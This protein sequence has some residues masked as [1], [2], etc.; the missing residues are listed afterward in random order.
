MVGIQGISGIDFRSIME[1]S[2]SQMRYSRLEP[3]ES[4]NSRL[5]AVNSSLGE[6]KTRLNDIRSKGDKFRALY[7]GGISKNAAS[8]DESVF[9]AIA[10]NGANAGNINISVSSVAKNGTL[11]F[12]KRFSG[13]EDTVAAV[14]DNLP[15][16]DRTVSLTIGDADGEQIDI[17]ITSSTTL[18]EF[19][20]SFNEQSENA[21]A[22]LVNVGSAGNPSYAMMITT[23]NSG[24][25]KG[26]ISLNLGSALGDLN[27]FNL[28]QAEDTEL[29][30]DGI[31]GTISRSSSSINDIL[32][33]VTFEIQGTGTSKLSITNDVA[34][35]K[36]DIKELIKSYN[37]LVDYVKGE[38]SVTTD[39]NEV[40]FGSLKD[41]RID[42]GILTNLRS[43]L[44]S[45]RGSA[46]TR[47]FA[48]IGIKTNREGGLDIDE[49]AL[50]EA[51]QNDP[52]GVSKLMESFTEALNNPS[53]GYIPLATRYSG[54]LDVA[55]RGNQTEI[56]RNNSRIAEVEK[57]ILRREE[58]LIAQ[59]GR[60]EG[61]LGSLQAQQSNIASL[62]SSF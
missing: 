42:D 31:T 7:G 47:I 11:S 32:V 10:S 27:T 49:D 51:I 2:L 52:E 28:S 46:T 59:Y 21:E 60:L 13:F 25:D 16:A 37:D 35:T 36:K 44:S 45:A 23:K 41:T 3:L 61:I 43:A 33:G 62:L 8:S 26:S 30:I 1:A 15:A 18:A 34:D 53:T 38:D 24:K 19:V 50:E 40:V 4:K 57:T 56:D 14:D 5:E 9:S 48:D 22:S 17:E 54:T 39:N 20:D 58:S 12:D 55:I 29:A 6:I